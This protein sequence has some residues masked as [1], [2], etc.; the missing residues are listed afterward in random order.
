MQCAEDLIAPVEVGHYLHRHLPDSTLRLMEATGHCPHMS[1]PE[2][3]VRAMKDYL[4]V[5]PP[6]SG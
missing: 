5:T 6:G 1:H 2:E 4:N 3:T